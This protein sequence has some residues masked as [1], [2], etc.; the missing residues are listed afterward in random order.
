M[1]KANPVPDGLIRLPRHHSSHSPRLR[2]LIRLDP[3]VSLSRGVLVTDLVTVCRDGELPNSAYDWEMRW[4]NDDASHSQSRS[5]ETP[6]T[7]PS[8][9]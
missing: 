8:P 5:W 1:S 4:S 9:V 7:E 3:C 2:R 6:T